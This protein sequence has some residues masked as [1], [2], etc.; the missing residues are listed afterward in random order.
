MLLSKVS[1][2][3]MSVNE[4]LTFDLTKLYKETKCMSK[5]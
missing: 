3:H 2:V 1:K 4:I 5:L